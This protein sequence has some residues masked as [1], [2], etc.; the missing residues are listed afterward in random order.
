MVVVVGAGLI[1]LGIACEL[2]KR[3][4][5]VRLIDAGDPAKA[6]SWAGAGMLAPF[7]EN[8]GDAEFAAFCARSLALY[9][10]FVADLRERSGVDP[11]LRLDGVVEAAFTPEDV[12]RL[13]ARVDALVERGVAAR[14]L[15]AADARLAEP[16]LSAGTLGAALIEDEGHVDNRRLGRAL[17]AEC[18]RLGVGFETQSGPVALEADAR[19]VLGVRTSTG[20]RAAEAVVNATGAWAGRLEGTP[21]HVRLPVRPVKGQMLA[22]AA[23]RGLVRRVLWVPGAYLV[24]REDGRLLVGATSEEADFDIRVTA[25]GLQSLLDPVLRA[26]PA[27]RDL[28]VSE[29]WAGLRP[30]SHDGKPYLGSTSLSGYFVAAGHY[31]N[32]ILLTPVTALTLADALEGKAPAPDVA[33][34]APGRG[35]QEALSAAAN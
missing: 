5:E 6:A 22:L 2:A 27:L 10:A 33:G 32:G 17:E 35:P 3:G 15:E 18:R 20:F 24:P 34:L 21:A 25:R 12:A 13:R 1:G 16:A 31:R 28:T 29:T 23:P 11:H 9:P 14:W 19:R 7:T 8:L 4:A 26:L 30:G